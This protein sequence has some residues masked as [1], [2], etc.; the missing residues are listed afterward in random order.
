LLS[1]DGTYARLFR[2]QV[3]GLDSESAVAGKGTRSTM[4]A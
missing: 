1:R 2:E 3:R 4:M